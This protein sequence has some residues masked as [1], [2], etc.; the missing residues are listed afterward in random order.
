MRER[1]GIYAVLKKDVRLSSVRNQAAPATFAN[2]L[3]P[4]NRP[5]FLY[6]YIISFS[7]DFGL[8]FDLKDIKGDGDIR[9]VHSTPTQEFFFY[10]SVTPPTVLNYNAI[11]LHCRKH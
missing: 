2:N 3:A 8:K 9:R 6:A 4:T 10:F 7:F 11:Q 1:A 5:H